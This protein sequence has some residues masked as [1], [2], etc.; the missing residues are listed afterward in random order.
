MREKLIVALDVP[1]L[2][3]AERLV[4]R[5]ADFVGAFKVGKELFVAE[6]PDVL[7]AIAE[8]GSRVFLDLKF[9]DIPNTVARAVG[10][11]AAQ[12]VWMLNV[13]A[14]GGPAMLQ[15]ARSAAENVALVKNR[16]RTIVIGVTVLTSLD[17]ADLAAVGLAG[18][19]D[20]AALRLAEL[21][22]A[23]GLDGVVASAQE[24]AAIKK[25]CGSDFLIVAPGIRPAAAELGDQKRVM[26]PSKAIAAGADYLVVGRPITQAPLPEA[27]AEAIVE[28]MEAAARGVA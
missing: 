26:T 23:N 10:A 2:A 9:H 17:A 8:R 19:P 1:N 5:L 27:A 15:A 28:E 14:S 21:A 3:T 22:H 24:A 20:E 25:A 18:K 12:G 4:D 13:H 7:R 11:A 6:G 16:E